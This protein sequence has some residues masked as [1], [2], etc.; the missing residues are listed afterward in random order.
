M[1]FIAKNNWF[2]LTLTI[3]TIMFKVKCIAGITM[4]ESNEVEEWEEGN[5][6]MRKSIAT[7]RFGIALEYA[8]G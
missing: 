8:S 6:K 4:I 1:I 2:I 3:Y 5:K 7:R